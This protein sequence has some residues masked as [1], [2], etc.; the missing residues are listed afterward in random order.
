MAGGWAADR[1]AP[2]AGGAGRDAAA[3]GAAR[4][5]AAPCRDLPRYPL[6]TGG[7]FPGAAPG[8]RSTAWAVRPVMPAAGA[9]RARGGRGLP[10]PQYLD[11]G[12]GRP[13]PARARLFPRRRLF[14]RDAGQPAPRPGPA[15]RPP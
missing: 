14:D 9:P 15:P 4:A 12:A 7:A 8:F 2:R 11:A 1:P 5:G 6:R 10:V 3:D 13:P